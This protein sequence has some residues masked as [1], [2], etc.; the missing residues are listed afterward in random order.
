MSESTRP[1]GGQC[2]E[3]DLALSRKYEERWSIVLTAWPAIPPVS[4]MHVCFRT[5]DARYHIRPLDKRPVVPRDAPTPTC[6]SLPLCRAVGI[7]DSTFG[8]PPVCRGVQRIANLTLYFERSTENSS[9]Y[10]VFPHC[11]P[12]PHAVGLCH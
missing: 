6:R 1:P 3:P 5:L 7:F 12:R 8:V 2:R 11:R 10:A 9:C 4:M